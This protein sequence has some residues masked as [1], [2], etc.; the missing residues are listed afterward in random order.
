MGGN[1][2]LQPAETAYRQAQLLHDLRAAEYG[3]PNPQLSHDDA[4]R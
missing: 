3:P 2:T 4:G 1:G